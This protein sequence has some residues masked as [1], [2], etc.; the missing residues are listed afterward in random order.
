MLRTRYRLSFRP[1]NPTE[2][3]AGESFVDA[4]PLGIGAVALG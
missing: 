2:K 3:E 1:V 4:K